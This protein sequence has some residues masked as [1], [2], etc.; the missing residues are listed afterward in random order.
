MS[1][2]NFKS[3]LHQ[4]C[5]SLLQAEISEIQT[6]ISGQK[7]GAEGSSSA[8]D[9]HNTEGAMQHL[10]LEKKHT[11][12]GIKQ[13]NLLLLHKINPEVKCAAVSI[14]AY[15]KTNK[16]IFYFAAPMGKINF[17]NTDI[18]VLSLA[19]PLGRI[20]S[21]MKLNESV[22]FNKELWVIDGIE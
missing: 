20:L 1:N 3:H 5:I 11:Q 13:Q 2:T 17:E 18:M 15:V 10:E 9:K 22:C 19:S 6:A 12:L 4:Y 21:K 14:G 8:G 7:E 16:G